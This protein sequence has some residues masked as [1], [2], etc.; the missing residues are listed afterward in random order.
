MKLPAP[1]LGFAPPK[2]TAGKEVSEV[3]VTKPTRG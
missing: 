1:M 2:K 3:A